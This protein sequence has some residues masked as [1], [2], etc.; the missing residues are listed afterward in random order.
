V[1]GRTRVEQAEEFAHSVT[2]VAAAER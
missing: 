2:A 1:P